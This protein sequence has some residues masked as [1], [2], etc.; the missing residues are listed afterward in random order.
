MTLVS[1]PLTRNTAAFAVRAAQEEVMTQPHAMPGPDQERCDLR[2]VALEVHLEC[3]G[4]DCIYWR[5]LEHLDPDTERVSGCA[6][7]NHRMLA[8]EDPKVAAWLLSVKRRVE[9][10]E[11]ATR[12]A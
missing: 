5:L 7:K 10:L 12:Q 6:I 8:D 9:A 4:E 2:E 1:S 11:E 3:D